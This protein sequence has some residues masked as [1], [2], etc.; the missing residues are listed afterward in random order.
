MKYYSLNY[1]LKVK[2]ITEK[3]YERHGFGDLLWSDRLI[4]YKT[5]KY[6]VSLPPTTA[7]DDE[8]FNGVIDY[9]EKEIAKL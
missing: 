4:E 9:I 3:E 1:D 2:E 6:I 8:N 7:Y 5:D